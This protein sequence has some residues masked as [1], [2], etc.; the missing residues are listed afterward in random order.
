MCAGNGGDYILYR[1]MEITRISPSKTRLSNVD[2][3]HIKFENARSLNSTSL[4]R[5]HSIN[6]VIRLLLLVITHHLRI[7][8]TDVLMSRENVLC[9]Y[10][11]TLLNRAFHI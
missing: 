6:V 9:M 7:L 8:L 11:A 4:S 5:I 1:I 3:P 10:I 2:V